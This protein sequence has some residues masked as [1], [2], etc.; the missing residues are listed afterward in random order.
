M[1]DTVAPDTVR[2]VGKVLKLAAI[3]D[4][5][6]SAPSPERVAAWS[7]QVQR[8]DLLEADLLD[9]LQDF[10]DGS[11]DHAI[12]IGDL[13]TA[14][15]A[16]RRD[17]NQREETEARERRQQWQDQR[18]ADEITALT[19]NA[20][21]DHVTVPAPSGRPLSRLDRARLALQTCVGRAECQPAMAEYQAALTQF[22]KGI[23][24]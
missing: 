13:I 19:H 3:L 12:G 24:A 6:M 14:A 17:R 16:R 21:P 18:T 11:H 9:G 2:A 7:A 5:R 22:K 8:H 10:Y 15:K 4:D 1:T 23:N 20:I